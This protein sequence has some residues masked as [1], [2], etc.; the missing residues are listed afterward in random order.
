M[1]Q[2]DAADS[3]QET[4]RVVTILGSEELEALDY[5]VAHYRAPS[6]AHTLRLAIVDMCEIAKKQRDGTNVLTE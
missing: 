6:R 4:A 5:L 1:K 3:T 2:T